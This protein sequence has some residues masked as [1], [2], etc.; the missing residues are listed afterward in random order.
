M[1]TLFTNITSELTELE[2]STLVPMLIDTLQHTNSE[3]RQHNKRYSNKLLNQSIICQSTST[4][5][6]RQENFVQKS[7][8]VSIPT[9]PT[10]TN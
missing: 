4:D 10:D 6:Q 1:L 2:K 9:P 7:T 3:N 5:Q 8:P